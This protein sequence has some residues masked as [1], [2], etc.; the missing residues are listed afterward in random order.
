MDSY[1]QR[2]IDDAERMLRPDDSAPVTLPSG[3]VRTIIQ[4]VTSPDFEDEYGLDEDDFRAE[5]RC[6]VLER[7]DSAVQ[8]GEITDMPTLQ[9]W[10]S[11]QKELE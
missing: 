2:I 10:L 7:L 11:Q 3:V 9:A 5:G 6:D 1:T 4:A 8:E